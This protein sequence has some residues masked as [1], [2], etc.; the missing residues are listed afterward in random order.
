MLLKHM[1]S[2]RNATK[3]A[4]IGKMHIDWNG[5]VVSRADVKC[6]IGPLLWKQ[7]PVPFPDFYKQVLH[8]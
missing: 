1:K 5:P 4:F 7:R 8:L 3:T 6:F 2:E